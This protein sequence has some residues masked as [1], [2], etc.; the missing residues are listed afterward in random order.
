MQQLT[1]VQHMHALGV[2]HRDLKLENVLLD[3]NN[4]CKVCD[5]GLA[6]QY[7]LKEGG[8]AGHGAQ[9]GAAQSY[10]APEASRGVVTR[11]SPTCGAAS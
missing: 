10:R 6:H 2:V 8:K 3:R 1:A 7:E 11:V 4:V 5:F 9:G